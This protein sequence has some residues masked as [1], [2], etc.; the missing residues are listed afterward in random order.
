VQREWRL[1]VG[2]R[3]V[4]RAEELDP[5]FLRHEQEAIGLIAPDG[6]V[7]VFLDDLIAVLPQASVQ[8]SDRRERA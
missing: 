1:A 7:D 4:L 6:R 8:M 3:A 5:T 2:E